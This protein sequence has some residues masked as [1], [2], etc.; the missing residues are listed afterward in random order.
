MTTLRSY[1]PLENPS[2]LSWVQDVARALTAQLGGLSWRDNV[3]PVIELRYLAASAPVEKLM[4]VKSK[5]LS[6]I[7]LRAENRTDQTY[8]SGNRITWTVEGANLRIS[9][10]DVSDTNDEYDV[11]L[12]LLMG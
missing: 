1:K 5:P 6:V 4:P 11:T 12:G 9:A 8:E 3:G 10:I 2:L 7:V